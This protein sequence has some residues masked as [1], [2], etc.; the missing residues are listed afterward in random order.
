MT[1][2]G[3][4]RASWRRIPDTMTGTCRFMGEVLPAPPDIHGDSEPAASVK[5]LASLF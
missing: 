1:V 3:D 5:V 2:E 4:E